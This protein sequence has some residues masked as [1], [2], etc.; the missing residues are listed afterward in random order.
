MLNENILD[1][2]SE[3]CRKRRAEICQVNIKVTIIVWLVEFFGCMTM[4]IDFL[5]IGSR[6]N[7][8]TGLLRTLTM[9]TYFVLLPLTFLVNCHETKE[10]IMDSSWK[11]ALEGIFK[12]SKKESKKKVSE[13]SLKPITQSESTNAKSIFMIS[14]GKIFDNKTAL[15]NDSQVHRDNIK[16]EGRPLKN[17]HKK[18]AWT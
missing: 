11:K 17:H 6:S 1:L 4:A 10:A 2:L 9:L 15:A 16:K 12:S 3:R 7:A 14:K 5:V 13:E 8:L 18:E